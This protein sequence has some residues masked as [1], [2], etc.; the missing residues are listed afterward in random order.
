MAT[1]DDLPEHLQNH[2]IMLS[3]MAVCHGDSWLQED[4]AT[5]DYWFNFFSKL[6]L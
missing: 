1:W 6:N 3:Y 2:I 5:I 4:C